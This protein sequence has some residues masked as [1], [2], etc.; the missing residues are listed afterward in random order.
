MS[1]WVILLLLFFGIVKIHWTSRNVLNFGEMGRRLFPVLFKDF[2]SWVVAELLFRVSQNFHRKT[3]TTTCSRIRKRISAFW[4]YSKSFH[5]FPFLLLI[6]F[7]NE[8]NKSNIEDSQPWF[9]IK[10]CDSFLCSPF[11]LFHCWLPFAMYSRMSWPLS[12]GSRIP[13]ERSSTKEEF[14]SSSSG[15][16]GTLDRRN[17]KTQKKKEIPE[18]FPSKKARKSAEDCLGDT[19][20]HGED[21]EGE[22]RWAFKKM[23]LLMILSFSPSHI[24]ELKCSNL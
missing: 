4:W 11:V 21:D 2:H 17:W 9:L 13:K 3:S 19:K 8:E 12:Q 10:F 14:R 16:C 24:S 7:F 1:F 18:N 6:G 15:C 5:I 20:E 22:N 23:S